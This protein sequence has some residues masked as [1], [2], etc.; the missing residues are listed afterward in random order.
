MKYIVISRKSYTET[1]L[2]VSYDD[3]ENAVLSVEQN[4]LKG[5]SCT[6][7]QEINYSVTVNPLPDASSG[8]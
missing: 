1:P 6:L 3:L 4:I 8:A 5:F 7:T 2:I